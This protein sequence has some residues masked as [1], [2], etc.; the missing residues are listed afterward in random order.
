MPENDNEK[1]FNFNETVEDNVRKAFGDDNVSDVMYGDS[2]EI[3]KM[4]GDRNKEVID[5]AEKNG[6]N[7]AHISIKDL[8]N[9]TFPF[10]EYLVVVSDGGVAVIEDLE[11]KDLTDVASNIVKADLIRCGISPNDKVEFNTNAAL[12]LLL[13]ASDFINSDVVPY[14]IV[15]RFSR[16]MEAYE[17]FIQD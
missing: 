8:D 10:D 15:R 14:K 12:V 16:L 13:S 17:E 1:D 4:V 11:P 7:V 9:I 5:K 6:M 3:K 2:E